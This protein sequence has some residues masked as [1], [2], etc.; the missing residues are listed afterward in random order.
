MENESFV[1][2]E[3]KKM[4]ID[5]LYKENDNKGFINFVYLLGIVFTAFMWLGLIFLGK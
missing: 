4:P 3:D 2:I 5:N 1:K